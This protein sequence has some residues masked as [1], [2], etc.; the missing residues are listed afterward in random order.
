[1]I[2]VGVMHSYVKDKIILNDMTGGRCFE[3]LLPPPAARELPE[4]R[5][6]SPCKRHHKVGGV[7]RLRS[8]CHSPKSTNRTK[9]GADKVVKP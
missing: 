5:K 4:S 8:C 1:M 9:I 3:K 7:G 2:I 6:S